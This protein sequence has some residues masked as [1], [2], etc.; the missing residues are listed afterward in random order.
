MLYVETFY[1][2]EEISEEKNV[3]RNFREN[4]RSIFSDNTHI[5]PRKVLLEVVSRKVLTFLRRI[6]LERSQHDK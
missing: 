3:S 6:F 4:S 5:F 2:S 1:L